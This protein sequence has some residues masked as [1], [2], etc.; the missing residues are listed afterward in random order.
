MWWVVWVSFFK[1]GICCHYQK[2]LYCSSKSFLSKDCFDSALLWVN[3]GKCSYTKE[4]ML[5]PPDLR[6]LPEGW[7]ESLRSWVERKQSRLL[8]NWH[9]FPGIFVYELA[10]PEDK[11]YKGKW[12]RREIKPMASRTAASG[13]GMCYRLQLE[14]ETSRCFQIRWCF[15]NNLFRFLCVLTW[16]F[17][18]ASGQITNVEELIFPLGHKT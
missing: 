13:T 11:C 16:I 12:A 9:F 10:K 18:L 14:T 15:L 4:R 2:S 8:S 3:D 1:M 5:R 6:V 17:R 7:R